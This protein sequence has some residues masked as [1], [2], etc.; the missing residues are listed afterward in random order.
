MTEHFKIPILF[1]IYNNLTTTTKVFDEIRK[2]KPLY[3]YLCQDGYRK[4][5]KNEELECLIVRNAVLKQIDWHCNLVTLFRDYNLG[6]GKGTADAIKWF[7]NQ[8]DSGIVLEH[9]CLPHPDFFEYCETLLN[10]YKDNEQ[11]KLINGSNYQ[12][13]K[14]NGKYSYYFGVTGSLWGWASWSRSINSYIDDI[15]TID[16]T[17]F[18]ESVNNTFKTKRER[19]YWKDSFDWIKDGHANTWDFQLMYMTWMEKGLFIL[20]NTNL[21]SNIGYGEN[22]IHCKDENSNSANA[23]TY[24]ILPLKHPKKIKRNYSSDTNYLDNYLIDDTYRRISML[25]QLKRF[26]KKRFL[27]QT[28][29]L[30]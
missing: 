23:Q 8:V 14:K 11:I 13:G 9:D 10:R 3:L 5:F 16:Y 27:P 25:T 15:N 28:T 6:P 4:N 12:V 21:I 20:P 29:G 1:Q 26:V 30:L 19:S 7:F 17:L 2:I 22:A 24:K 18:V